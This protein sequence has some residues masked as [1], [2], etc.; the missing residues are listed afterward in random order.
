MFFSLNHLDI[1]VGLFW[2]YFGWL[3]MIG[4]RGPNVWIRSDLVLETFLEDGLVA[5][6]N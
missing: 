6:D 1:V 3:G 4:L 5:E 2:L